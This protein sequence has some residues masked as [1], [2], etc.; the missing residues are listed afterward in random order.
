MVIM[1]P[2]RSP[3]RKRRKRKFVGW[4]MAGTIM[5]FVLLSGIGG[6]WMAQNAKRRFCPVYGGGYNSSP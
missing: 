2:S 6:Y 5:G 4:L 1:G 3:V